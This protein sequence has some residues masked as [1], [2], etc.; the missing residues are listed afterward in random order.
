MNWIAVVRTAK[1]FG[2]ACPQ[3]HAHWWTKNAACGFAGVHSIEHG[4]FDEFEATIE[5]D[6]RKKGL[7]LGATIYWPNDC[8]SSLPRWPGLLS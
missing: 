7:I 5:V 4:H 2:N 8:G 6:E 1:D 3:A